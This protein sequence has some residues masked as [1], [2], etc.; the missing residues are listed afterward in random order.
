MPQNPFRPGAGHMPP[1]LAGRD[2]EQSEFT[3]A[4]NQDVILENIVLTGLRGV[5][6]TVL[7][8][9]FKP[10]AQKSGW[11]WAG[12]DLSET[13]SVSEDRLCLRL[14]TDLAIAVSS[15]TYETSQ[16]T[17][18]GFDQTPK[19]QRVPLSFEYLSHIY[20]STPGMPSDKLRAVLEMTWPLIEASSFRGVVFVYDESQ[21]LTD[22]SASDQYP[23]SLLLDVFQS[24]QK[25]G[26]RYMLLLVGLPTLFPKLVDARTFAERMFHVVQ[27]D[28]LV[29]DDARD[30]ICK[31]IKEHAPELTFTDE[32]T[33]LII[34]TSGGYPYFIQFIC[35]EVFDVFLQQCEAGESPSVPIT[36]I[37]RKLDAD[38]FAGRWSKVTDR[39]RVLLWVAAHL[40]NC[41]TD[42]TVQDIVSK[43]KEVGVKQFSNSHA[44]QILTS[45]CNAGLVYKTP[46]HGKYQ[47]AV[48]LLP[49]FI[50]RQESDIDLPE[51]G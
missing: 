29:D 41:D 30:A 5:G 31:P 10:L 39:Q 17:N 4:L 32:S 38:F 33:A 42:F 22:N 23:L 12:S 51:V 46:R 21:N 27:L 1:Y 14:I 13:V 47:F 25:K 50:R 48:P 11:L 35:K 8:D 7:A 43:S 36:A 26:M 2:Q 20:N 37:V 44:S 9:T 40:E 34:K 16:P 15:I 3:K 18:I 45:L 49:E 19:N 28:K 6:K 24:I